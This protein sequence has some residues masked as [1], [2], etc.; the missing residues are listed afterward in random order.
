MAT[1]PGRLMSVWNYQFLK[2][3]EK[4]GSSANTP[5]FANLRHA[6]WITGNILHTGDGLQGFF[7]LYEL[8]CSEFYL[9]RL[10][11]AWKPGDFW[12]SWVSYGNL[13]WICLSL[14]KILLVAYFN[15]SFTGNISI[16]RGRLSQSPKSEHVYD[17]Y[18]TTHEEDFHLKTVT[19]KFKHQI[20][21]QLVKIPTLKKGLWHIHYWHSP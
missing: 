11:K 1:P 21:K 6:S 15:Y 18:S 5:Y 16:L 20:Q 17:S 9:E 7:H 8:Y 19:S 10:P 4:P 2:I 14:T 12:A 13:N 3:L